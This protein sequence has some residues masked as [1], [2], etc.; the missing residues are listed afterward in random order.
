VNPAEETVRSDK[1]RLAEPAV[2]DELAAVRAGHI[3]LGV[4][5]YR[6]LRRDATN[7]AL[8][9]FSIFVAL[10]MV[11][12]GARGETERQIGAVA[13]FELPRTRLHPAI[14]AVDGML[15]AP[16]PDEH[17]PFRLETANAIWTQSGS[18]I[19]DAYLELLAI[20]YGAG[21]GAV[22]FRR[23]P[24]RARDRINAWVEA[25]TEGKIGDLLPTGAIGLRTRLVLTNAVYF[26]AAWQSPFDEAS[27][28]EA[29]FQRLDGSTVG[30][31]MIAK[32]DYLPL[33]GGN[34]YLAV[35]LPYERG[36]LSMVVV[37]PDPGRFEQLESELTPAMLDRA[38][39]GL[40]SSY[41]ELQLPSF[42]IT[43]EADLAQ[44]LS[45]LGLTDAFSEASADFSGIT[46]AEPL[47]IEAMRHK[48]LVAVDEAGT[49]A[50]A[51]TAVVTG[52][53]VAYQPPPERVVVDRPFLFLL[54]EMS[55]QAILFLG[56]V[57]EPAPANGPSA[58]T[59]G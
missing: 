14:N 23:A 50:A 57:T 22:D 34:G 9:P 24:E 39:S 20:N 41:V 5:L 8:A 37:V 55:T 16:G 25:R 56:R 48:A 49:E 18:A 13:H 32:T 47:F 12:A 43:A 46:E 19:D 45:R 59:G 31:T 51:A 3:A 28:R 54:R 27:T 4:D 44:A 40:A 36:R 7:L 6:S 35:E 11:C 33:G 26:K 10:A 2:A 21:V 42:A 38:M 52:A 29:E 15:R 58:A 53:P 30:V 17:R 1:A